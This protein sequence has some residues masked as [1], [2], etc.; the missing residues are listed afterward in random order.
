MLKYHLDFLKKGYCIEMISDQQ[1]KKI[2]YKIT[3]EGTV[4]DYL[5]K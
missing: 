1:T 5:D 2:L 4:V 3:Q